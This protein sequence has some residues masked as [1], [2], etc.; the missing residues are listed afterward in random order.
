M[1]EECRKKPNDV[2]AGVIHWLRNDGASASFVNS[3]TVV[4]YSG[5]PVY[6]L[7]MQDNKIL[8][9]DVSYIYLK[10]EKTNPCYELGQHHSWDLN[11]PDSLPK[12][13]AAMQQHRLTEAELT[14]LGAAMDRYSNDRL[15]KL[16]LIR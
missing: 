4:N 2:E 11:D 16:E 5:H 1:K 15:G 8:L 6:L 7:I 10:A 12:M 13:A 14:A 3:Y 9:T